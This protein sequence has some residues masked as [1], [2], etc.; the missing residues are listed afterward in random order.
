MKI[1]I[2]CESLCS[3][4]RIRIDLNSNHLAWILLCSS[5][6]SSQVAIDIVFLTLLA[7]V[8]Q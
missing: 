2:A 4:L 6:G 8:I 3:Q 7:G 5:Y 1:Q